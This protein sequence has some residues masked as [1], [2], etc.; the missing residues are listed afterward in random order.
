MSATETGVRARTRRAIV[1]AAID[2]L[3]T[4]TGASMA[5][6]AAAAEVSRTTVHR[7]FPERSDLLGAVA[8]EAMTRVA[9][10]TERARLDHGPAPDALERAFRE[11]FDLG[12]ELTLMFTGAIVV[13]DEAWA[14]LETVPERSIGA[15]VARGQADGSVDPALPAEWIENLLWALLYTSWSYGRDADVPRQTALD[16]CLRSLRKAIAS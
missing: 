11:L 10:A 1:A 2:V 14:R 4:D 15:A 16:L 5:D 9:G 7:Y 3:A 13:P 6:V 8:D 12:R